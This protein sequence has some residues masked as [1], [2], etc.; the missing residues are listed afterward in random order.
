M[1]VRAELV[2]PDPAPVDPGTKGWRAHLFR[3][4]GEASRRRNRGD[5]G[6]VVTAVV[7]L[8]VAARHSGEVTR[9]EQALF[10]LFNSLPDSLEPIFRSAY[11]LG[12]LWAVGLVVVAALVARRR[13]LARD[14][15][16]AGILAW[17][18]GRLLGELV[19]AHESIARSV[20]LVTGM[21]D[22]PSFPSVRLAVTTAVIA[23][24]STYLTRP[25][26]WLG[27]V[28]VAGVTVSAMYLGTAY[29][30]DLLAG[31]V[32]G[33][34][35]AALVHLA[36]GAPGARPTVSPVVIPL[37][38]LAVVVSNARLADDQPRNSTPVLAEDQAGA[39]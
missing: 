6:R 29:P 37:S 25:T 8:F 34:G 31:I 2:T 12:T 38:E 20:R 9:T 22:T 26:R 11:R 18:A 21:A 23:G 7:V 15:L 10:E 5:I 39:I 1:T 33:W 27:G 32:L 30:D 4:A 35:I 36:F 14:L 24:A 3:P 17:A 28:V 13:A 19:V 16:V